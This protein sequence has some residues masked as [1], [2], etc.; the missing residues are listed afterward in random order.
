MT[1]TVHESRR[2]HN[3]LSGVV[4]YT[5]LERRCVCGCMSASQH[6]SKA[7]GILALHKSQGANK[8]KTNCVPQII[9]GF[10]IAALRKQPRLLRHR[11]HLEKWGHRHSVRLMLSRLSADQLS[12]CSALPSF[13]SCLAGITTELAKCYGACS[14][15]HEPIGVSAIKHTK[16]LTV[17][18]HRTRAA[19]G[20]QVPI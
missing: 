3:W 11:K 14:G 4:G 6:T 7:G 1:N 17:V 15:R 10:P 16:A 20:P 12:A 18:L 5:V 2:P 9:L 8:S 13:Q 19:E